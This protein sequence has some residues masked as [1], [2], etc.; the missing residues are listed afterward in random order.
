MK[1]E[2][3]YTKFLIWSTDGR[4]NDLLKSISFLFLFHLLTHNAG[5]GSLWWCLLASFIKRW[6]NNMTW[7]TKKCVPH[8]FHWLLSKATN[9]AAYPFLPGMLFHDSL[10][11]KLTKFRFIIKKVIISYFVLNNQGLKSANKY[12]LYGEMAWVVMCRWRYQFRYNYPFAKAFSPSILL[13]SLV[14]FW[15]R[16]GLVTDYE[17]LHTNFV[18]C[19]SVYLIWRLSAIKVLTFWL[20]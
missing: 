18:F 8:S 12:G 16:L 2:F 11:G 15:L 20:D 10:H 13:Y 1:G 9:T 5:W 7:P 6:I 3:S 14:Y 4:T 17:F 19:T